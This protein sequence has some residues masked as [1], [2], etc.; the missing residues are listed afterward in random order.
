MKVVK[1]LGWSVVGLGLLAGL[2][3]GFLPAIGT[4]LIT[5]GLTNRGFTHV[6]ITIN[7]PGTRISFLKDLRG[8]LISVTPR[9]T[10]LPFQ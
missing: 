8:G 2:A 6:E 4:T 10:R 9:Q 7:R 1:F 3:Y 5:Q